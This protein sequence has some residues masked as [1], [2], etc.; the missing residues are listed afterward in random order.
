MPLRL[1]GTYTS[2]YVRIVR[3]QIIQC[4]L[5]DAVVHEDLPTRVPTSPLYAH[6]PTGKVPTLIVSDTLALS[7]TRMVCEYLDG[8]HDG[9]P[10]VR[11]AQ[12]LEERAL[13]GIITGCLDGIAVWIREVRRPLNEQSP[14]ILE[15]E[16]NRAERCCSWLNDHV[17][18]LRPA[19]DYVMCCLASGLGRVGFS[20]PSFIW[21]DRFTALSDWLEQAEASEPLRLTPPPK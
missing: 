17:D 21:R 13:E 7:E 15:Q 1:I 4:G 20:V 18:Q 14:S 9:S 19:E 2:P 16:V 11:P 5:Q 6:N 12:T 3:M 8:L 10:F